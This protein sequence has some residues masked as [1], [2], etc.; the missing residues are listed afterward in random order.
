[1]KYLNLIL[2]CALQFMFVNCANAQGNRYN[3][4]SYPTPNYDTIRVNT[5]EGVILHHTAE[6]TAQR[7]L[8]VLSDPVRGVSTH[9]VIDYDG[10]R[11]IMCEPT[12]VAYHAGKSILNGKEGCNGFTI[13]IE[14]QGNTLEQPLTDNQI[15]SA[16]EYLRPIIAKYNIPLENIVTHQMVRKAFKRKYPKVRVYD[17]VDITQTEYKRFMARIREVLTEK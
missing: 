5:V 3:E 11:Y 8:E 2:L 15:E 12:V 13:G 4:M 16:I 14:F 1:M 17:K 9:C 6:P 10:T 7:S